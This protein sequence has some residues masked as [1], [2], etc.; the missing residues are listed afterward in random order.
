[1]GLAVTDQRIFDL[2]EGIT[3]PFSAGAE[4]WKIRGGFARATDGVDMEFVVEHI[5]ALFKK[6]DLTG[7]HLAH[8]KGRR[9]ALDAEIKLVEYGIR[10]A[11]QDIH[12]AEGFNL[13]NKS[14]ARDGKSAIS[15]GQYMAGIY[16]D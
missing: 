1:M 14:R 15:M 2:L 12:T 9:D 3:D 7:E 8:L 5:V 16:D 4:P 10:K 11:A 6:A 13:A